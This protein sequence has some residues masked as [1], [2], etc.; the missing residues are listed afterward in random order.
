MRKEVQ[1]IILSIFFGLLVWVSDTVFDY[2]FFYRGT[3]IDLLIM[4]VP[5]HEIYFRSQ[6]IIFFAIFGLVIS[7][8]FSKRSQ[9]E[10]ALRETRD[11]LEQRVAERTAKLS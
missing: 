11:E 6:V 4:D 8:L 9:A 1:I 3:F 7:H 2:L 10:K 5:S